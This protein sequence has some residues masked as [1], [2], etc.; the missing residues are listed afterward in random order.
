MSEILYPLAG[1]RVWV[2][3]HRGMVGSAVARR[4]AFERCEVITAERSEVNLTRQAEV[5]A[6]LKNAR[7][8]AIVVAAAKV[9]GILAN[10][11][12]PAEF[13]YQNLMIE[14]NIV[15]AAHRFDV[16][17]LLFLGSSCIYPKFAPQ[18]ITE[19]ALLTGPLEP[20]NEAYAI[21]K[22]AGIKLCQAYRK[23]Y[24]RDYISAMPTN[25]YGPGDNFD[26]NTGHVLPALIRKAHEAKSQGLRELTI[27]G[28]GTPRREFLHV[29]DC[30]D[31]LVHLLKV[32]SGNEHVN[33]GSGEDL[34]IRELSEL[35]AR[36]V[37]YSGRIVTDL[38]KPDGTPRKLM[39]GARLA[40]FGWKARKGL[41][42]GIR[43]TYQWYL[44]ELAHA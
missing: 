31:A 15:E 28:S 19:D 39:S 32:Y 10:D 24:G 37:G 26:L 23:Q 4:L 22:I 34:T 25:L 3:G 42:A 11:T 41:E 40:G 20:S 2:A 12:Q 35:V 13:L 1:K 33:V 36:V 9:G 29:D 14:A 5:E 6:W 17:R 8:D 27:W 38:S 30:A 7:A 21:A 18:P 43:E 16:N 44:N